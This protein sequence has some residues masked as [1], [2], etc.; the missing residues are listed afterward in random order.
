MVG[1]RKRDNMQTI[2]IIDDD[3]AIGDLEQEVLE[4]AGYAV[5]RAYSSTEALDGCDFTDLDEDGN[6]ELTAEFS[7]DDGSTAS[8]V[9]FYVD[10]GLVYNEEFS[11]LPDEQSAA[12][13][14]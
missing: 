12:G 6:S 5:Q 2:L 8:L 3:A 9:W 10:G 1:R 7:F 11:S 13:T 14:D 4:R